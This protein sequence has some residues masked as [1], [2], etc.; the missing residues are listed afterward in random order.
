VYCSMAHHAVT[1]G[2]CM[3]LDSIALRDDGT[4]VNA[5]ALVLAWRRGTTGIYA[6]PCF[7]LVLISRQP[8]LDY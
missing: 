1:G 8:Q 6:S 2:F 5:R 7:F 3:E 4:S